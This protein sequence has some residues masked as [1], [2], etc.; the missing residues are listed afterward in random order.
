MVKRKHIPIG[1]PSLLIGVW[2]LAS[3]VLLGAV[4][5]V[6]A[7][8]GGFQHRVQTAFIYKF[9]KFIEWPDAKGAAAT[10]PIRIGVLGPGPMA[11]ALE[12]IDGKTFRGRKIAVEP[13]SSLE[14]AGE[15][16]VVFIHSSHSQEWEAVRDLLKSHPVLTVGDW[17]GFGERGG[18]LNFYLVSNKVRFQI[19][20]EEAKKAGL[21]IS[22]K[23]LKLAQIVKTR[24]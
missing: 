6:Q 5:S 24:P 20:Y 2:L 18:I 19:N 8:S 23:V 4:P 17:K 3:I 14:A 16:Q 7:G 12:E 13:L 22:S 10:G 9:F 11:E 1:R 15:F 21:T